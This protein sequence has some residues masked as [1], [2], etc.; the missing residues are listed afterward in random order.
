MKNEL[1][2][3]NH[4]VFG[5]EHY[6]P[7]GIVRSL[8]EAG[9]DVIG[10][11]IKD[12]RKITSKSKYIKKM[13]FV[14]NIEEGYNLLLK[15]FGNEEKKSFVYASDDQITSL[16]DKNYDYLKDRFYFYNAGKPCGILEYMDK[17]KICQIAKECGLKLAATTETKTGIIP[18]GIKYPIITK[19]ISST[20]DNWKNDSFI[21]HNEE[22]LRSAFK[23]IRSDRVLIQEYIEKKNE[24]C[25]DGY[26]FNC[27]NNVE[28]TIA[29]TYDYIIPNTYSYLMTVESLNNI[30][31]KNKISKMFALIGFEGIFSIEFLVG[32]NDELYF[33]EINFRNSTWSYASTIAGM[34]LPV[35]WA[36]SMI[37]GDKIKKPIHI[38]EPFKAIVEFDDFRYR[39]KNGII[40]KVQWFKEFKK[41]KCKY[42]IGRKDIK[43]F[44]SVIMAKIKK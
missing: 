10:I 35:M 16:M 17:Y 43:P 23:K 31:L 32:P 2:N 41:C 8:G 18:D 13:Y 27:G 22:E 44:L 42:Y 37:Y 33:L 40:S 7:L 11:I 28:I 1:N 39:V 12:R 20:I 6:N 4:I 15:L 5:F 21:C 14:D 38:D 3:Y 19:A 34:S 26:S 9:I 36:Y 24:L 30:E 25:L 29:S